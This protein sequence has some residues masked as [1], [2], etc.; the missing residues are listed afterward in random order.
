M[1][2]S[3]NRLDDVCSRPDAILDKANRAYKV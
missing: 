1:G 3:Y 2:D